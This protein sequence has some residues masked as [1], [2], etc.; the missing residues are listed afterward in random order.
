MGLVELSASITRVLPAIQNA[1]CVI[2]PTI[3]PA[4]IPT[5]AIPAKTSHET[6]A[7]KAAK[8]TIRAIRI[9]I[10]TERTYSAN[11]IR[12]VNDT[13]T[14]IRAIAIAVMDAII[15]PIIFKRFPK[16]S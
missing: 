13:S 6:G 15:F 11:L 8:I 12:V 1:A 5:T 4:R 7:R 2:T 14:P 10:I 3:T 9:P 16:D